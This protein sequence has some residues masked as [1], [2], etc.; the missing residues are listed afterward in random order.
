MSRSL[1]KIIPIGLFS[2]LMVAPSFAAEA[3]K[4]DIKVGTSCAGMDPMSIK[5]VCKGNTLLF[6]SSYSDYKFKEQ[7]TCK[8]EQECKVADDGKSASCKFK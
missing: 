6:C 7:T 2:L 3:K 5:F 4:E 8:P 1:L